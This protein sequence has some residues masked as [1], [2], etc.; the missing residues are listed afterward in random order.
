MTVRAQD[1]YP[2]A[3]FFVYGVCIDDLQSSEIHQTKKDVHPN[4]FYLI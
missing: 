4:V 2:Q 3:S 1:S